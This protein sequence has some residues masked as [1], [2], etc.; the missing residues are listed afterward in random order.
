M[1]D[2]EL[3][4]VL[5]VN[6]NRADLLEECIESVLAQDHR[7]IEVIV[8]DNG[9]MDGSEDVVRRLL[10]PRVRFVGLPRNLGFAGGCN[11]GFKSSR[12]AW[13]ALINN[14][15]VAESNW[16]SSMVSTMKRHPEAGMC[17]SRILFHESSIVDKAGH[18][19]FWDGQNRGRGTGENDSDAFGREEEALFP[20]G[21]AALYRRE[22]ILQVRGFDEDFFAYADDADLGLRARLLGW[23]CVYS[24]DAVVFHRHSSTSGR[25]SPEKIYL[26]ERNRVWLAV[27]TFPWP[28]LLANPFFTAY[29][30][31][32]NL[33]AFS[34]GRGAAGNFR[35]ERTARAL[36]GAVLRAFLDGLGGFPKML[37]KRKE[38][39]R[40]RVL[41]D[42]DFVRLLWRFRITA[43]T[44]A[45]KDF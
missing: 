45:W 12:G 25:F 33:A 36:T 38:I 7:A 37:A 26:V 42:R 9:S 1:S 39:R 31:A 44:L 21:C 32:W 24:P 4:S 8:V 5:I 27:K 20:D 18:L 10:D 22:L 14:D 43:R 40:T 6:H 23:G 41:S 19:I 17:A 13:I 35:R 11:H 34:I 2:E 28:L 29:R 16:L 30:W 15:A 3:V